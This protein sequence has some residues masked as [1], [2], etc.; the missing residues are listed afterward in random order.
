[1]TKGNKG[2]T[3][4]ELLVVIAIIGILSGIVLTSLGSA[5]SKAKESSAKA[6]MSSMRAEAELGVDSSGNYI[7]D[8]CSNG[9]AGTVGKLLA[10][11]NDQNVG[12]AVCAQSGASGATSLSWAAEIEL[13]NDFFCVDST[14]SAGAQAASSIT[15]G[16]SSGDTVCGS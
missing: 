10:A 12:T 7:I 13:E 14:G 1:M 8:V 9:D 5:R 4:I 15:A 6:S 16:V 2:F 3:L 11:A